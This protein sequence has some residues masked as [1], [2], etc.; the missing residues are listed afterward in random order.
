MRNLVL[1]LPEEVQVLEDCVWNVVAME[2][3]QALD[4]DVLWLWSVLI[5]CAK[6]ARTSSLD[7]HTTVVQDDADLDG[8][9][10][11]LTSE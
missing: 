4:W 8:Q 11:W 1:D 6:P 10:P 9:Y 7:A 3:C 2:G 5:L